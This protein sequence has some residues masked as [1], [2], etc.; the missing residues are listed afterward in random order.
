[1]SK[2]DIIKSISFK[3]LSSQLKDAQI[4]FYCHDVDRGIDLN[5]TAYSPLIDSVREEFENKG[6]KCITIAH[7]FSTLTLGKGYG[8]PVSINKDYLIAKIQ[9]RFRR[10][11]KYASQDSLVNL[12]KRILSQTNAKLIIT[13]GS[14]P[15]LSESARLLN[16]FHLELLHGIGYTF[17]PWDWDKLEKKNLPQGILS[18]DHISSKTFSTL[19][20]KGIKIKTIPHPFLKR[21][22]PSNY[23]NIPEQWKMPGN[24]DKKFKKRILVSFSWGYAGDHG[25]YNELENVL[26]N[27]L[28]YEEIAD[29][30]SQ[31]HN[32]IFWYFRFHPVQLRQKKYKHLLSYMDSFVNRNPNC[33]W[34]I[35]SR[36][37][38]PSILMNC[39]GNITMSSM[40][41]YD[42]ASMGVNSLI[43]CPSMQGKGRWANYFSDLVEEGYVVK[44]LIDTERIY[45]WVTNIKKNTPRISNI[46]DRDAYENTVDWI[47]E[48]SSLK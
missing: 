42:A 32:E 7:P 2:L 44:D 45:E 47:L 19:S 39:D 43:L 17:V 41:C 38:L 25:D 34:R 12:Y 24:I 30:I 21:F 6:F 22:I 8:N 15:E 4:I 16:V 36:L 3:S 1:M 9:N 31:T 46:H 23:L 28:F 27:G 40:S 10:L 11:F 33:E 14:P 37:P 35:S 48:S 20:D 5:G 26:Q 29:L 13:I 18:L